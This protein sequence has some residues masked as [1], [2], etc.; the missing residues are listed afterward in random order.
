MTLMSM[1]TIL[2]VLT[3]SGATL[4]K[5]AA[6][7]KC[8][9]CH[10]VA[11]TGCEEC[12][13]WWWWLVGVMSRAVKQGFPSAGIMP[14]AHTTNIRCRDPDTALHTHN[15][16]VASVGVQCSRPPTSN[17]VDRESSWI[18]TSHPATT[19]GHLGTRERERQ[20]QKQ[21]EKER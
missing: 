12:S 18:L 8:S 10:L 16:M 14:L 4:V 13:E 3:S 21:R 1:K 17:L 5:I 20:R 7:G 11:E 6:R 15:G 19:W 9:K 2:V